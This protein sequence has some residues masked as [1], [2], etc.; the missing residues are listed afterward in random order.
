MFGDAAFRHTAVV[1]LIPA[2][3]K[4]LTVM[5][6]LSDCNR[7]QFVGTPSLTLT[8]VYVYGPAIPVGTA[9]VILFPA[10]VD[11]V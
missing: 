10:E 1:P 6:A 7:A 3:G 4:G 2:V 9:T 8:S 11:I 5:V